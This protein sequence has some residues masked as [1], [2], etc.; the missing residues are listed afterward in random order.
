MQEE[1]RAVISHA[2]DDR[3]IMAQLTLP[4]LLRLFG[5]VAY[6]ENSKPFIMVDD[7]YALRANLPTLVTDD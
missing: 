7:D 2:M 4:E 6:D 3:S 1:K 5:P